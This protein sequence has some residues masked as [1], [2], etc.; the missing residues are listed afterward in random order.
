MRIELGAA[1]PIVAEPV[2]APHIDA[3]ALNRTSGSE[4]MA[5]SNIKVELQ[6]APST[7]KARSAQP[8]IIVI[9]DTPPRHDER[10]A[11][12][13]LTK[14]K[15]EESDN[16]NLY[17]VPR[18]KR[19]SAHP[20]PPSKKVKIEEEENIIILSDDDEAAT[21]EDEELNRMEEE[22]LAAQRVR[23]AAQKESDLLVA[24][25][26]SKRARAVRSNNSTAKRD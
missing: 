21:A 15:N 23:L 20:A 17:P 16:S 3:T 8:D 13:V 11:P 1:D 6:Q 18:A 2:D 12:A 25:N 26:S 7:P 24:L 10:S 9:N 5:Q 19:S 4:P 14:T 22:L